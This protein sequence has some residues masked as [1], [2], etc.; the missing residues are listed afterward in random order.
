MRSG[1]TSLLRRQNTVAVMTLLRDG[2]P[3]SLTD[4]AAEAGLSRPTV[5]GI[6]ESLDAA[7]WITSV[8]APA[9]QPGRPGRLYGFRDDGGHVLGIDIGSATIRAAVAD[10][11]GRIV[12]ETTRAVSPEDG[13]AARLS[14]MHKTARAALR[15]AG[16][17]ADRIGAV[18][19]GT[20]GTVDADGTVGLSDALPDWSGVD[21]AGAIREQYDGA[22]V[23]EN[24]CHLA[25]TAEAW[26][27]VA[28]GLGNVVYI[29]CG[30]RT[31]AGI[32]IDGRLYRGAH[33]MSG[34]IGALPVIGWHRAAAHLT[35]Y[36]RATGAK[37]FDAKAVFAAAAAGDADAER[38]VTRYAADLA[39]GVAAL[40]LTLD[41]HLVVLGGGVSAAQ[42]DLV[43]PLAAALKPLCLRVPEL[44]IST[45][46]ERTV[47]VGALKHAL[48]TFDAE[49]YRLDEPLARPRG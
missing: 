31:G 8:A 28:T 37:G 33:G 46:G 20:T 48:D 22:V 3:R 18:C 2:D 34:E 44:A 23:I 21:L 6:V 38:A 19:V 30:H 26:K 29:H 45:L 4:L 11:S 27:G 13:R 14:A 36:G 7:G 12:G 25:A 5:E 43:R 15:K 9:G 17:T 39:E 47:L 32:L 35:E 16:V 41:P 24:D 10:L 40:V 1:D 49:L 42:D